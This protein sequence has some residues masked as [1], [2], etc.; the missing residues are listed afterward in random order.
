L[1]LVA[2]DFVLYLLE[3]VDKDMVKSIK[4]FGKQDRILQLILLI[5]LIA[6][7]IVHINLGVLNSPSSDHIFAN[8]LKHHRALVGLTHILF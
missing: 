3:P 6:F 7:Q 4:L 5:G 1:D 2:C 8:A